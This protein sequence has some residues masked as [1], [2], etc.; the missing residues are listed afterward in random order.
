ML[1]R[2]D[3]R[4]PIIILDWE[5]YETDAPLVLDR[6]GGQSWADVVQQANEALRHST[7]EVAEAIIFMVIA[8]SRGF[9]PA[10]TWLEHISYR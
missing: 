1:G 9:R 3:G 6:I 10:L 8:G 4:L 7:P 2:K 5:S